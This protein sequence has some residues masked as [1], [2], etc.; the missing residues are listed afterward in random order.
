MNGHDSSEFVV[1]GRFAERAKAPV[2]TRSL[3]ITLFLFC[4]AAG[5]GLSTLGRRRR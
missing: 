3:L 2:P 1:V 4:S 5:A